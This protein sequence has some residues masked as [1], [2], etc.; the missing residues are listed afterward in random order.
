MGYCGY[1]RCGVK[2]MEVGSEKEDSGRMDSYGEWW[3]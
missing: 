1:G 3:C 2:E